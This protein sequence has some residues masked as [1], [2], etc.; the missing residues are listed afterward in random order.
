MEAV[1]NNGDSALHIMVTNSDEAQE[2]TLRLFASQCNKINKHGMTPLMLAAEYC[3]TKAARIL[4][5]LGADPNIIKYKFGE[6]HTA[7]SIMLETINRGHKRSKLADAEELTTHKSVTSLPRCCLYFFS[8]IRRD[9]R[10]VVQLMVTHGM[11]PLCENTG[12][13]KRTNY[14]SSV[15]FDRLPSKLFP[16]GLAL[17]LNMLEI[18]QYLSENWFLTP[19]DLVGSLELR[20]LRNKLETESQADSLRFMDENL[21]QPMPLLK[22]RF[23]AVSAQLGGVAG[24]EE[25]VSQTPLPNILKDM[26][27]FRRENFPMDFTDRGRF[28]SLDDEVDEFEKGIAFVL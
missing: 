17:V 28:S 1:D 10:H 23:V 27:L 18:A 11:A 3:N 2:E 12:T 13:I 6:S 5:G 19:A 9:E 4:L 14:L 21:S 22:L 26:L 15:T 16:L 20:H 25:R 8:M 7:L 24:R